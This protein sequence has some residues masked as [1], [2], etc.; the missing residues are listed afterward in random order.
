MSC[1]SCVFCLTIN[2]IT[3]LTLYVTFH[4][5]RLGWYN[6][7][8]AC[9]RTQRMSI[10][11]FVICNGFLLVLPYVMLSNF[12]FYLFKTVYRLIL[13]RDYVCLF[14]Q[15]RGPLLLPDCHINT[16]VKGCKNQTVHIIFW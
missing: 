11:H 15:N 4:H 6:L 10:Y 8:T 1:L 2:C 16:P 14:T 9:S 3:N 7:H 5:I 13:G 12:F